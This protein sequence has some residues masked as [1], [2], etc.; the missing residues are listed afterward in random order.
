VRDFTSDPSNN[1]TFGTID[2]RR[3]FTNNMGTG[4]TRLRFRIIDLTTFPAPS[5]IAD[6][7]PRSSTTVVVTVDRPP[8]GSGTSNITV[9]GTTLEVPP[10]QVNGGGFNSSMS[11]GTVTLATPLANG[12]SIDL[13]FLFGIQQTGTFKVG[14]LLEGLPSGGGGSDFFYTQ[15]DTDPPC[16]FPI[17]SSVVRADADPTSAATVDYDVTFSE[18]VTGVDAPDFDLTTTGVSGASVTN[19]TGSGADYTVT[20]NTG[21]GDGTIR[22]D[23]VDDDTIIAVKGKLPLGDF[24]AGN[25]D[26]TSGEVYTVDK[27]PPTCGNGSPDAGEEC[28]NGVSNSDSTPDAC[29]TDCTNHRC[30]DSV[31]DTGEQCDDGGLNSD[32]TPNACRTDCSNPSCGDGVIDTGEECDNGVSNSDSTPDACRTDCTNPSCGDGVTDSGEECDDGNVL[33]GD[34][35]SDLCQNVPVN[36]IEICDNNID[37]DG[38]GLADCADLD[39]AASAACGGFSYVSGGGCSLKPE[40]NP[41]GLLSTLLASL[42]LLGILAGGRRETGKSR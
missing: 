14:I 25:G 4:L 41:A 21:T 23:V 8:C 16:T 19:V 40:G 9:V 32:S 3:T 37:D 12:A 39:C 29:R 10:A 1:S 36:Q 30:G 13:R 18:D 26:F 33:N 42:G 5:G 17:V 38:D 27:V 7:R 31:T 15:C 34:G 24:G 2:I 22:L 35:C 6:L 20:V 11:A 28:D